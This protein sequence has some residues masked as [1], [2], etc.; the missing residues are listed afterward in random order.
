VVPGFFEA[1]GIETVVGR[2]FREDDAVP[3]PTVAVVNEAMAVHLG[4]GTHAIGKTIHLVDRVPEVDGDYEVVGVVED[5]RL[6]A[7]PDESGPVAYFPLPPDRY[8]PGNAVLLKVSGDP[9]NAIRQMEDELRAIDPRL[10]IVN[11]ASYPDIVE[12]FLYARRMNAELFSVIALLGLLLSAAGVFGIMSL[13]VA[14]QRREI[15]IR[16][17]IG[18][19]RWDIVRLVGSRAVV[20][21]ALGLFVGLAVAIAGARLVEGLLWGIQPAD[22]VSLLVGIVVLVTAAFASAAIPIARALRAEPVH[23]LLPD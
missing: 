18:A 9:R 21:V 3:G 5:I 22:P 13:A 4:G 7:F 12:G 11:I 19:S 16:I 23:T 6:N 10:A 17:A 1:L 15:G 2:T 8:Y 20:T 14:R